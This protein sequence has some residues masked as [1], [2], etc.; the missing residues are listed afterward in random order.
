M[1]AV[2]ADLSE[3]STRVSA[4]RAKLNGFAH[5]PDALAAR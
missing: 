1:K 4:S 5:E 3:T 2:S